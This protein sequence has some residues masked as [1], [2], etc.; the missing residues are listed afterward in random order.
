MISDGK[1][2]KLSGFLSQETHDNL[3]LETDKV[4]NVVCSHFYSRYLYLHFPTHPFYFVILFKFQATH[5]HELGRVESEGEDGDGD[6]VDE[7][8][9]TVAH[10]L[11]KGN[12]KLF[13]C[14]I[15]SVP[16]LC[17]IK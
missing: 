17:I 13:K 1:C 6:D 10:G 4:K 9:L 12:M 16:N 15:V 14:I 5:L 7:E 3:L 2:I 8:P 11:R